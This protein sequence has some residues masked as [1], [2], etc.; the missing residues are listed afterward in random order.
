MESY[1]RAARIQDDVSLSDLKKLVIIN[2]L[3]SVDDIEKCRPLYDHI[4]PLIEKKTF[5]SADDVF[6][7]ALSNREPGKDVAWNSALGE[8]RGPLNA[9]LADR[10]FH[11]NSFNQAVQ[12][13]FMY[14][15][16]EELYAS[17]P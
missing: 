11:L 17:Q 15:K 14:L 6:Y 1:L 7:K 8:D 10:S 3:V 13:K 5:R 9:Y 12:R 4:Q 16:L 2:S